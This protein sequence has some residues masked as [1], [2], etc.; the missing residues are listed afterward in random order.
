MA[1][2]TDKST[3]ELLEEV[4]HH[5]EKMDHRDYWRT[6]G[7]F[8]R[9]LLSVVPILV[10]ILSTWYLYAYSDTILEGMTN[11]VMQKMMPQSQNNA[12]L[13]RLN[14]YLPSKNTTK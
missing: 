2:T 6:W 4:L 11:K 12:L 9:G 10:L 3:E 5:M 7:G 1:R 14:E 8:F 13:D